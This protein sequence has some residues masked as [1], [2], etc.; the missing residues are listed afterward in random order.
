MIAYQYGGALYL[1]ITNRCTNSCDFCI[2]RY[3]DGIAG[4]KLWLDREPDLDEIIAA[5]GDPSG[6]REIVFCGY[7][8]PLSRLDE[9]LAVCRHLAKLG[10]PPVRV[11]TNGQANLLHGRNV[12]PKL[13]GLVDSVSISLNAPT[14]AQ[15]AELCHPVHGEESYQAMLDFAAECVRLLPSVTMTALDIPGVDLEACRTIAEGLGARFRVR[16]FSQAI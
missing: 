16:H 4:H 14:A 5:I 2:R 6:Y 1:N 3:A 7:G 12:V 11:D 10:A 9:V 13:A 8:E 15:Y